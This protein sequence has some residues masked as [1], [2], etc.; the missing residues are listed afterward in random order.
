MDDFSIEPDFD[1][2]ITADA[3]RHISLKSVGFKRKQG[4]G[5]MIVH[6]ARCQTDPVQ[7][8]IDVIATGGRNSSERPFEMPD[9]IAFVC[10]VSCDTGFSN[11]TVTGNRE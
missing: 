11:G 6:I 10:T 7:T 2:I 4:V 5:R 1:S 9:S 3:H 8:F